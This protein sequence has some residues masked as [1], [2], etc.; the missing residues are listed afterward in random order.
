MPPMSVQ[1]FIQHIA[2]EVSRSVSA[3]GPKMYKVVSPSPSG[4]VEE[5]VSLPQ[6]LTDLKE[7]L[8]IVVAQNT[9]IIQQ[10]AQ[11]IELQKQYGHV[12]TALVGEMEATRKVWRHKRRRAEEDEEDDD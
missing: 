5:T 11:L 10:N 7:T 12:A 2:A 8:K 9:A 6:C 4:P 1:E 3:A